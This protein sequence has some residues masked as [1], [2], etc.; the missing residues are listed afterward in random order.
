[1]CQDEMAAN[2]KFFVLCSIGELMLLD[3]P[4]LIASPSDD[5][6]ID[7]NDPVD[8]ESQEEKREYPEPMSWG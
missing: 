3:A 5:D 4:N 2:N 8:L 6:S 7:E 1:M